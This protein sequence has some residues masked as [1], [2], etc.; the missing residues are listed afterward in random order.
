LPKKDLA[1]LQRFAVRELPKA[2]SN[3]AAID[4]V[5]TA[6]DE[7]WHRNERSSQ[8]GSSGAQPSCT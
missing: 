1:Q 5:L 3:A 7:A 4:R 2:A 8:A 6:L